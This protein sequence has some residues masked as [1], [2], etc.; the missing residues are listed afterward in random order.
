MSTKYK[1]DKELKS[2][3]YLF[4][5]CNEIESWF[6]TFDR[7]TNNLSNDKKEL[8]KLWSLKS[9]PQ[10]VQKMIKELKRGTIELDFTRN[11]SLEYFI[12]KLKLY[13]A[14]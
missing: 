2:K 3:F 6:L 4:V 13:H 9:E 14:K 8:M 1:I 10:I 11:K 5:I 12:D 7:D